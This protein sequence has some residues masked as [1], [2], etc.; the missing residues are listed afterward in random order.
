M[1][2]AELRQKTKEELQ[3]LLHEKCARIDELR[4]L[5]HQKKVKNVK[6]LSRVKKDIARIM[7]LLHL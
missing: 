5:L 7:T 1:K 2:I 6:E 3:E 4:P